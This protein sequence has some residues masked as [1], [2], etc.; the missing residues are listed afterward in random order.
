MDLSHH[1]TSTPN[2][3]ANTSGLPS[4]TESDAQLDD[5]NSETFQ[6][7]DDRFVDAQRLTLLI[8]FAIATLGSGIAY[9]FMWLT[10]ADE[11][12]RII[13]GLGLIAVCTLLFFTAIFWP[14]IEHRHLRWRLSDC[15]FEIHRGVFWKH[16]IAVPWARAQHADVSQGPLQRMFEMGSLTIHTAGTKNSSVTLDGLNH[17]QAIQLRDEIIRQRKANDV[18]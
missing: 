4:V 8:L 5:I 14:R 9:V 17:A 11:L 3:T 6:P 13:S 12:L 7:V 1:Q 15:G 10:G 2:S 18:V 16:Q